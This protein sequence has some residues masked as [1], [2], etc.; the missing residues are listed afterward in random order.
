MNNFEQPLIPE[1]AVENK[2]VESKKEPS[3]LEHNEIETERKQE[4][5]ETTSQALIQYLKLKPEEK[6]LILSDNG[7]NEEAVSILREALKMTKNEYRELKL[8]PE[9]QRS[10]IQELLKEHTVVLDFLVKTHPSTHELL[11]EDIKQFG[12]RLVNFVD[13]GPD[14][15]RPD[16]PLA[17]NLE[18]LQ[19]R[20]NKME[21]VL[22]NAVCFKIRTAYGTD[23]E[24]GL[25][26]EDRQ[27]VKDDGV[28]N[29]PGQWDNLPGGEIYTVPHE[30][31][32][33][34]ILILP[35]VDSTILKDQGV[36]E[37]IIIEF[38]D[39]LITN[40]RGG[41]SAKKLREQ[42]EKDALKEEKAGRDPMN[43]YRI[44]EIG[45]GANSK[46]RGRAVAENEPY[47][48]A[49]TSVVESEKSYGT[50]HV[51]IGDSQLGEE[52][53]EGY[54]SGP[55][56]YDFILPRAGGLEVTMYTNEEDFKK[57]KNGVTLISLNG[58][59]LG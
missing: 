25:R 43:V 4:Y 55:N 19:E 35:A 41:E 59:N 9:I 42:L 31:R 46:A 21:A 50:I 3:S 1:E 6:I 7:S 33:N 24:V 8:T 11:D 30:R 44:A 51:A 22:K 16:G 14:M 27:W 20:L 48:L 18:A 45:F 10:Q 13:V 34:G 2:S 37:F 39:G 53:A 5:I 36:D 49:G 57:K 38:K 23:L 26:Y 52:G 40:I 29:R 28:I 54:I 15:F 58:I 17:E 32:T 56:H 47:N 12:S